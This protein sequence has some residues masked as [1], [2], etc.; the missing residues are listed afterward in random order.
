M[1]AN[2]ARQAEAPKEDG[3][4][5]DIWEKRQMKAVRKL[6]QKVLE[7]LQFLQLHFDI[8]ASMLEEEE[9]E[10]PSEGEKVNR[11][12]GSTAANHNF[13]TFY[14]FFLKFVIEPFGGRLYQTL[15]DLTAELELSEDLVSE[16]KAKA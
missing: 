3:P 8:Q 11:S 5:L 14:D 13:E 16:L 7:V 12:E 2:G 6:R 1:G 10:G 9:Q 4:S 15:Y